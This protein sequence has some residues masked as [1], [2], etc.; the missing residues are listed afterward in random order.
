MKKIAVQNIIALFI[1][2]GIQLHAQTPQKTITLTGGST[3]NIARD[4]IQMN[5]GLYSANFGAQIDESLLF[6]VEYQTSQP[7][8]DRDLD[9]NLPVGSIPGSFDVS[10][11][12]AATYT[13]PIEV[14]PGTASM[15]PSLAITYNS[16]GGNGLLGKGWNLSGL[17]AITRVGKT[18]YH[19]GITRGAVNSI[20]ASYKATLRTAFLADS[21]LRS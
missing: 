7:D 12:G 14:P 13:I 16:Q 20:L 11:T 9:Y 21:Q 2:S 5:V 8:P 19:D 4:W 17:S 3:A 18:I 6:D 15:Q 10:P 1:I